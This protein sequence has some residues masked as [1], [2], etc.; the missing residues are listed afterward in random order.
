MHCMYYSSLTD[1]SNSGAEENKSA[2]LPFYLIV[3]QESLV[4]VYY[5][6]KVEVRRV[7]PRSGGV[8]FFVSSGLVCCLI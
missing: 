5:C 8:I 4:P 1:D 7:V 2:G 3:P 6:P